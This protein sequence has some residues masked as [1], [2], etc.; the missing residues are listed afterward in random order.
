MAP[1]SFFSVLVANTAPI[2]GCPPSK[3]FFDVSTWTCQPLFLLVSVAVFL[4][5]FT[6]LCQFIIGIPWRVLFLFFWSHA[7]LWL[8]LNSC[9]VSSS[10]V[11]VH[12]DV[13]F[14]QCIYL[15]LSALQFMHSFWG[16]R[17]NRRLI[18]MQIKF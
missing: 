16:C 3:I 10:I 12:Y 13:M 1:S 5:V 6:C 15:C 17:W 4:C 8:Y 18:W 14:A 11:G 2:P 7:T 9:N